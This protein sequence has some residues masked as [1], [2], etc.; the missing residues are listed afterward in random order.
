MGISSYVKQELARLKDENEALRDEISALQSRLDSVQTLAEIVESLEPGPDVMPVLD[1]IM[2][3][4]LSLINASAG[5]L[6]VLDEEADELVF[7]LE[8]G[9][10][11]EPVTGHRMPANK[12]L[13]GWVVLNRK[14]TIVHNIQV[15]DRFYAGMSSLPQ[16]RVPSILAA[17]IIGGGR[18]LGV[19]EGLNKQDGLPFNTFD[20]TLLTLLCRVAGE[21]LFVMIQQDEREP[22]GDTG[23]AAPPQEPPG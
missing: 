12:G 7:V 2:Y 19:L 4:A 16:F 5:F 20:Q 14:S 6:L 3:G 9:T 21:F 18:V 8:R 11:G 10:G 15:D 23:Q 22:A 17:P 13:A 1:R